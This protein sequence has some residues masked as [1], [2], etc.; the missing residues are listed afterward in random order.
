MTLTPSQRDS[1]KRCLLCILILSILFFGP[2]FNNS[3]WMGSTCFFPN[4]FILVGFIIGIIFPP[5][6]LIYWI[7]GFIEY[8]FV[9]LCLC[10]SIIYIIY[11]IGYA[12][13]AGLLMLIDGRDFL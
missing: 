11:G 12:H 8:I 6:P 3:F 10:Y 5:Q 9:G 4:I 7:A 1:T 13:N 2:G